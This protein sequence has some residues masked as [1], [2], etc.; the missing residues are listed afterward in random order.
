MNTELQFSEEAV[1][2]EYV[3]TV[4]GTYEVSQLSSWGGAHNPHHGTWQASWCSDGNTSVMWMLEKHLATREEAIA[5]CRT[6]YRTQFRYLLFQGHD[7]YPGGGYR[8]FTGIFDTVEEAK[9]ALTEK[10]N[11]MHVVDRETDTM[12]LEGTNHRNWSSEKW[13][14]E[15]PDDS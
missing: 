5:V 13:E 11:W 10:S 15:I 4:K 7:Y 3:E 2:V 9:E 6:H 14:F 8:D 12:V 1:K